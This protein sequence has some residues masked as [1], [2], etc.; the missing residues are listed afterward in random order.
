MNDKSIFIDTNILLYAYDN[1]AGDK[2]EKAKLLVKE[3]WI[4]T[5]LPFISFQV[6]Q[7]FYVNFQR[8]GLG[9]EKGESVIMD[10]LKWN[11]I[12]N[13]EKILLKGIVY[14]KQYKTSFWDSLII[15]AANSAGVSELWTEDLTEGQ[16][17]GEVKAVNPLKL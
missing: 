6:L 3:I 16:V 13:D 5:I 15:A 14:Q 7:E 10:F 11:I 1:Q 9:P 4:G 2:H 8:M 17:Y 12:I